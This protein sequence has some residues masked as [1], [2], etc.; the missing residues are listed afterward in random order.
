[1]LQ[2]PADSFITRRA[3]SLFGD[4]YLEIIPPIAEPG[5]SPDR[6]LQAGEP[7]IHVIEGATTDSAL[8]SAE[9]VMPR[10]EHAL[11]SLGEVAA[12]G[13]KIVIGPTTERITEID[14]YLAAGHIEAPIERAQQALA[15]LDDMTTRG[16]SAMSS[17]PREFDQKL[18]AVEN[19]VNKARTGIHD[20]KIAMT[21]A[22][23]DAREGLGRADKQIDDAAQIMRAIN[24][25]KGED[26]KGKLG[27]LVNDPHLADDI[28]DATSDLREGVSGFNRFKAWLG[29]R[30][31]YDIFSR[32]SRFYAVAEIKART[33][34]VYLIEFEK[35]PL[36]G[37]PTDNLS[38]A[39]G[40]NTYLRTQQIADKIRFTAQFGKQLGPFVVRGGIKDSTFGIGT[41]LLLGDGRL[42]FSADAFGGLSKT[43]RVK[44]SAA[45]AVFR[46]IYIV[47]GIDDAFSA[48]GYLNIE[49]GNTDVPTQFEEVRY[50]RD[51]FLGAELHFDDADLATLL[52]V[53]GA[54]LVGALAT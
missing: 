34:K 39:A 17:L 30:F 32:A 15:R 14:R 37:Y 41:D 2:I 50:G 11:D 44:L 29:G 51:Y 16:A 33:D 43:P 46:S 1:G 49:K 8:R 28:E 21:E 54:L 42:R 7:L 26:W 27:R 35:G 40:T 48:P 45:L 9:R 4:S 36:G 10:M 47:G 31:E 53:Y 20:G 13:R 6:M 24:D 52:R 38:D 3:D 19:A 18:T 12:N 22:F 23:S 5:A 25:G